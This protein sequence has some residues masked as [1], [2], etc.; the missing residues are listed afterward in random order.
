MR[1]VFFTGAGISQESGLQTFRDDDG[2]WEGQAVQEVC[3]ARAWQETP[4]PV[5]A[6]YNERRRAVQKA[7][8]NAAHHAIAE[9]ETSRHQ[10]TIV[11]QNIDDLHERAGSQNVLHL[12]GQILKSRS[13]LDDTTLYDCPGDIRIGDRATDGGQLRPHVV[14][15]GEPIYNYAAARS[16]C[17][18]AELLIVVG[19]SLVVYPAV[20]LVQGSNA[21]TLCMI[22]PNPPSIS[23][24]GWEDRRILQIRKT[25]VAGI[26]EAISKLL[27]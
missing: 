10:I 8:P 1:I 26:P 23:R 21:R 25:A 4:E 12:H 15:F 5:L 24:L 13:I 18:R 20:Y 11:T 22:D 14:F 3:S 17:K 16:V 19:T 27:S 9:L 2:L 6:F 7:L